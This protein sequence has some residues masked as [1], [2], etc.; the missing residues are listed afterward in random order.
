MPNL[1]RLFVV[2]MLLAAWPAV[3][4]AYDA[5]TNP[6]TGSED[7][8]EGLQTITAIQEEA[9]VYRLARDRFR[10]D[11]TYEAEAVVYLTQARAILVDGASQPLEG[12]Y[13]GMFGP[14]RRARWLAIDGFEARPYS[15]AAGDLLATAV[16][17]F[18]R[19][20]D[21]SGVYR[22]LVM[23]WYY[24]PDYPAMQSVMETA[25]AAAERTQSFEA[26]VNLDASDPSDVIRV[27]GDSMMG[28]VIKLYRFQS[29]HGD[30]ETVA[31]RAALG[32]ARALMHIKAA[33]DI[34]MARREYE[35]FLDMYPDHPLT[36]N[37]L[38]ERALS[39][40][41]TYRGE[42]YDVGALIDAQAIINQAEVEARGDLMKLRK[43]EAYRKRIRLWNQDRD[44]AVANWYA[45]RVPGLLSFLQRPGEGPDSWNRG[46]RYYYKQVVVRDGSSPQGRAGALRLDQLPPAPPEVSLTPLKAK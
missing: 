15:K 4:G 23:L 7:E 25:Q 31:P 13:Y 39:Y 38:C 33:R 19:A 30:R 27:D 20:G 40:L 10:T 44:L 9:A 37:A 26:T 41:V 2:L 46:A 36:F 45:D 34:W 1:L 28:D 14:N 6:S 32:L 24:L 11:A 5:Q 35:R 18:A 29:Q 22:H 12:W 3:V 17:G 16:E 21:I 43:V 42:D 8:D